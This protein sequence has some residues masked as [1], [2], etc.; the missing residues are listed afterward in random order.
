MMRLASAIPIVVLGTT[1]A[2]DGQR[3]PAQPG[4]SP[5][6]LIRA[7]LSEV[8][9]HSPLASCPASDA[10][11]SRRPGRFRIATWNIRG[12]RSAPVSAI[13]AEIGT[14]EADVVALQEV[15][16]RTR[17]GGWVDGPA[18]LAGALGFQYVFAA[19]IKWD[20]GD[21]GLAVLARWPL[22]HVRRHRLETTEGFE[23]RIVLE[24]DVCADG[25]PLRLFNH[26]ADVWP[27]ARDAGFPQFERIVMPHVGRGIL[28]AADFN[29]YPD[30]ANMRGLIDRGLIDLN[31]SISPAPANRVDY[32]LADGPLARRTTNPRVWSTDKSDHDAVLVDLEW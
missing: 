1:L 29:E 15:D 8:L 9:T 7:E 31:A 23:P 11:V 13:A 22:A 14:M 21:Y 20:E 32:L 30:S 27:E 12:A 4:P 5:R 16:V 24:V 18:D 25:R 10:R 28:V 3:N 6:R 26:H 17:R 19:S 2:V